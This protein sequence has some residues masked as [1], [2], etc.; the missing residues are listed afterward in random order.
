M[1]QC[2][3]FYEKKRSMIESLNVVKTTVQIAGKECPFVYLSLHQSYNAHH[4]FNIEVNY[5]TLGG[6]WM[7]S[8]QKLISLVGE[9]V[10]I[11]MK[12]TT[13]GIH[14]LF[15]GII[16]NVEMCGTDGV[17]TKVVITGKSDTVHLDGKRT[18]D[19]YMNMT[20]ENIVKQ[21]VRNAGDRVVMDITPRHEYDIDYLCQYNE[22]DFEFLNRLSWIYGEDLYYTGT[23]LKFGRD[24]VYKGDLVTLTYDV[25]LIDF[26][27]SANLV[28]A[29]FNR[30]AYLPHVDKEV[31]AIPQDS[32]QGLRGYLSD[33]LRCSDSIYTAEGDLPSEAPVN[34]LSELKDLVNVERGRAV[35]EMLTLTGSSRTCEVKLGC[36]VLVKMPESAPIGMKE[37]DEFLITSIVH[38]VDEVGRYHNTFSGILTKLPA[39]PMNAV[40]PPRTGVQQ[41]TVYSNA[42]PQGK[43]RVQVQLQWQKGL[44]KTTNWIRVQTP[45]AGSSDKVESNRGFVCIPEEG[46][47]VMVGFDYG[48]PNR[49]YVMGSVFSELTG[50]GGGQGNK[51]KS[52]VSRS[53]CAM[54][55]DDAKGSM[56][57][58]DKN[59]MNNS[60]ELDGEGNLTLKADASI[61][62]KCGD[63]VVV[64]K[65]KEGTIDIT[66]V[67]TMHFKA[68]DI[69]IDGSKSIKIGQGDEPTTLIVNTT[70]NTVDITST[71]NTIASS[72][73]LKITGTPVDINQGKGGKINIK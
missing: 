18:M 51:G 72:G 50:A 17:D 38:E 12:H 48:D 53:G 47:S 15:V 26:H 61:T 4:C 62:L 55:L 22:T 65:S 31:D 58:H 41:G 7:S 66:A 73:E 2:G 36:E 68:E 67:H 59:G 14:N 64:I 8:P 25:N 27:L 57:M 24:R 6:V 20:L 29:R 54:K 56:T 49:P 16:T 32:V 63:N 23:T 43:G 70:K 11:E 9:R 30:Y 3:I 46:D 33:S 19:S 37:V 35:A 40:S 28:P 42:D 34:S 21:A 1:R 71:K 44:D 10:I 13:K 69:I 52:I 60:F 5:A 39:V 45:D